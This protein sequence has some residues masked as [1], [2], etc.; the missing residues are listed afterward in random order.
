VPA[1]KV[2]FVSQVLPAV[3][4]Y[5]AA[6]RAAGHAPVALLTT[7]RAPTDRDRYPE[8][9]ALV[10]EAPAH[11]DVLIPSDRA[12]IAGLIAPYEPDLLVCTGFPWRI[13]PEALAVPKVGAINGHPSLLP[14]Y[15]GPSP[16]A[17]AMRNDDPELGFSFH[18]MDADFDTGPVLAQGSV[19]LDD[20]DDSWDTLGGKVAPLALGLLT[21][22]LE[23]LEAGD[24]G[25]PQDG[26][27]TYAG[28]FGDDYVRI[29]WSRTAREVHNQVRAWRFMPF[30]PAGGLRGA[31]AE[32]H[33]QTVRIL[34][35]RLE[36]GEGERV[37]C[38]DAPIWILETE[39]ADA[40]EPYG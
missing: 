37:E 21:R 2:V 24:P 27:P 14:K 10:G 26:E 18:R 32:L 25:D 29:D 28:I 31:V 36:P 20:A 3:L 23:R 6:L 5:D 35:T 12:R 11:L 33:G 34:R 17:W 38:G 4:G 15:R 30:A 9:Q 40:N 19:P 16:V 8:F 7:R 1:W 13:P 22:A 39:A